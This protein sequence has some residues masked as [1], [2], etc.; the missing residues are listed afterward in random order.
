ML[1]IL[2]IGAS[3]IG[4]ACLVGGVATIVLRSGGE[5]AMRDRLDVLTGAVAT[6]GEGANEPNP[7]IQPLLTG[8]TSWRTSSSG[9]STCGRSCSRP[10]HRSRPPSSSCISLA[11][12]LGTMVLC[13]SSVCRCMLAAAGAAWVHPLFRP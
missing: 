11:I 12:G 5:A 13:R 7:V 4:V 6:L 10:T 2:I 3:F 1:T 9:S 8:R